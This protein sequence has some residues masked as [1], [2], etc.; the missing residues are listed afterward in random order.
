MPY[1]MNVWLVGTGHMAAAHLA[2]LRE[3]GVEPIVVGRTVATSQRFG[4]EHAIS[5]LDGGVE[6]VVRRLGAP[7]LAIIATPLETLAPATACLIGAGT[8]RLLVEK[9]AA[10][11]L[12]EATGLAALAADLSAEVFVAYNRRFYGS[13][14]AARELIAADGGPLS[15]QF[16]FTEAVNRV[17]AQNLPETILSAWFIANST[18]VVDLAFHLAG[19][20]VT[21]SSRAERALSWHPK[22]VFVG[23]GVTS[24][25]ALFSYHSNW[26][27]AGR[28]GVEVC[29]SRRR[30]IFRP[31]EKLQQM[32]TGSFAVEEVAIDDDADIRFKPGLLRQ[33]QAFLLGRD[34]QHL[35]SMAS[36]AARFV[37]YDAILHGRSHV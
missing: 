27:S 7:Q 22:G 5:V 24:R 35:M 2:V 32:V 16:D 20:P 14:R 25:E 29:T 9:P 1:H 37:A 28:W 31:M 21:Y 8:G 6:Q 17:L 18:H 4:D 26:D 23:H 36:Q 33:C 12:K 15:C 11:S 3:L 13:A 19:E 30:L 34:D 10:L